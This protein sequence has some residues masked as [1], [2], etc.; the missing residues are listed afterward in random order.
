MPYADFR[1]FLDVLRR[2]G[3][4]IDI[5]RPIDLYVDVARAL[6]QSN[7]VDGPALN[8]AANGT[9]FPLVGGVY[10]HRAKALLA[11]EATE[12]TILEKILLRARPSDRAGDR[13]RR[14]RPCTRWCSPAM[15]ST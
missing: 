4:L 6:K 8:F 13:R 11:F 15:L 9:A 12:A 7:V 2:H 10:Q 14:P 3:E 5:D 1:E